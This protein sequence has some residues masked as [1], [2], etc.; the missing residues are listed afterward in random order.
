MVRLLELGWRQDAIAEHLQGD[1]S[2][3]LLTNNIY[4]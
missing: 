1:I 3:S 4:Q 2:F